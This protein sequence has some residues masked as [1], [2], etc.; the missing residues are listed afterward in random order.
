MTAD[1]LSGQVVKEKEDRSRAFD[2]RCICEN[3]DI[4]L[5]E[6]VGF[7]FRSQATPIKHTLYYIFSTEVESLQTSNIYLCHSS[8]NSREVYL[9]SYIL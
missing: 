7:L 4:G 1:L 3:S 8:E 6:T 9:C 2:T 5:L